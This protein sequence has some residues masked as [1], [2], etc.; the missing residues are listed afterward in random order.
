MNKEQIINHYFTSR[1]FNSIMNSTVTSI[2]LRNEMPEMSYAQAEKT[3]A[4]FSKLVESYM[5]EAKECA[6]GIVR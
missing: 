3:A 2:N 4:F 5:A 6:N 1:T